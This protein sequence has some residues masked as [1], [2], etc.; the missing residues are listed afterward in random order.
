MNVRIDQLLGE[1]L[2]LPLDERTEVA[3]ALL[4]SLESEDAGTVSDVWRDEIRQRKEDI[5]AGRVKLASWDEVRARIL[6]L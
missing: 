4:D 6:A 2:S 3:V 1:I 5:R